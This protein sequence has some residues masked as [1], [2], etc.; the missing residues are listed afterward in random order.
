MILVAGISASVLIQTM[1]S[2]EQQAME[3][4]TQTINDISSGLKVLRVNGYK[5]NTKLSQLAIFLKTI[6]GSNSIDLNQAY[7]SLSDSSDQVI[8]NYDNTCY[9]SSVSSSLF[10]TINSSNLTATEYGLIVIRDIDSSCESTA[11]VINND[12]LVVVMVNTT[13]CFSGLDV[14]KSVFGNVVPEQGISGVIGFTTP[15]TFVNTI[16]ELQP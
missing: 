7:I 14:R 16:I 6:S 2:L 4:G 15:S 9:A 3:T 5:F 13:S 1:N 10:S 11:P 12:D 8:L